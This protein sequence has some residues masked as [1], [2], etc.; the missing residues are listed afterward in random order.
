[1]NQLTKD[2]IILTNWDKKFLQ[3][4]LLTATWSKDPRRKVG[5]CIVDPKTNIQLSG[6][7]N[8]LPRGIKDS[9]ERLQNRELKL[10]IIVHA[11]ANSIT[12]AARKG[13]SI[14]GATMYSS[15]NPCASCASLIIQAGI[16][17]LVY[18]EDPSSTSWKEDHQL[19]KELLTE[20]GVE[21]VSARI[22]HNYNFDIK[23]SGYEEIPSNFILSSQQ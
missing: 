1:M 19:A 9:D 22:E 13:H 23:N 21:M 3:V 11:E 16:E 2:Q 20:A 17:R 8:G 14:E 5:C 12:A 7:Y 15:L 4:A 6:G 10:K 18:I